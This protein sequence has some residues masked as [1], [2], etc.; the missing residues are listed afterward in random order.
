M[1][2]R[3]G[4]FRALRVTAEADKLIERICEVCNDPK[5]NAKINGDDDVTGSSILGFLVEN[6][7]HTPTTKEDVLSDTLFNI[8]KLKNSQ[9]EQITQE[10]VA[11]ISKEIINGYQ[12]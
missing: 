2:A 6:I 5:H 12:S 4:Y 9:G 10:D 3:K 11:K 8:Y 7:V 1:K